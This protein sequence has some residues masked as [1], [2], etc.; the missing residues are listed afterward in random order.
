MLHVARCP[1]ASRRRARLP[2]G[3]RTGPGAGDPAPGRRHRRRGPVAAALLEGRRAVD[4]S[5]A[6]RR[7]YDRWFAAVMAGDGAPFADLLAEDFCYVDIFGTVR[8]GPGYHAL[9]ADIPAGNLVMTL[10]T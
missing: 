7:C 9:L 8:D 2:C 5:A 4:Q 10:G 1:G 3:L 6:I